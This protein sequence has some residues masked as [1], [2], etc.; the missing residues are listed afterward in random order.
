MAHTPHELNEDFPEFAETIHILRAEDAHFTR[1]T[2]AYHT[3]T[4]D[5]HRAETNVEPTTDA[6]LSEMRRTRMGLKDEIYAA[7]RTKQTPP[8]TS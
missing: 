1:I 3:I 7:L 8:A 5:I 4:R 6:H 2:D